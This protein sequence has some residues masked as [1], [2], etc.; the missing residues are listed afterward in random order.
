MPSVF[1]TLYV[2]LTNAV[3]ALTETSTSFLDSSVIDFIVD[4]ATAIIGLL[5][6]QPLGTFIAISIVGAIVG[7][8]T[9]IV[10]LARGRKRG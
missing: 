10:N 4:G 8:V 9:A 1:L 2:L 7:L 5:S 6:I 3:V